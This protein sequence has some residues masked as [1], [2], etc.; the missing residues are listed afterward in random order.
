[1]KTIGIKRKP[2]GSYNF[3]NWL[4]TSNEID[5]QA[6]VQKRVRFEIDEIEKYS[7]NYSLE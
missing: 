1:M 6:V 3:E 2:V 5:H 4:L 7:D